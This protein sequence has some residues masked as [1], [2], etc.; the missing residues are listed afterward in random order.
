MGYR[1]FYPGKKIV[2]TTYVN[3]AHS[4]IQVKNS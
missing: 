3:H 2:V 1:S 4:W